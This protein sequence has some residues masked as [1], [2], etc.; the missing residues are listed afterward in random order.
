MSELL[1][2]NSAEWYKD[3]VIYQVHVRSFFD[4][5]ADGIGDFKG[6]IQ[7][8]EYIKFLGVTAIWLLPFYP[9]PLKDEGYDVADYMNINPIY[10][11][12]NEFKAFLKQAH[13][14]NIKVI[15]EL[16]INHTSSQHAW[17]QRAR[18]AKPG[19]RWRNFYTWSD[20]GTEYAE[21][22]VIFNHTETSNWT[23]DPV[24]QAFYWHRFFS[25]QPDLN[26]EN[27][28]VQ[29]EVLKIVDFWF[30]LGV[31]GLRL[32]A[33]PYLFQREGTNCENLE[34]THQFLKKLNAH[35]QNKFQ[36]RFL[37]AE[38]NQWSEETVKYF[39]E[40]GDECQMAY[41]FPLLPK[42][43][44]AVQMGDRRPLVDVIEQTP[45]IPENCQWAI[46]LRNHD[47]LALEM[48]TDEECDYMYRIYAQDKQMR[49]NDG[50]RRRLAPLMGGDRQKIE[51]L[52]ALLFSLPGTPIIYY[53]DEI[54]MGD[55]I[56]LEDRNSVRTPM[57]WSNENNAGFSQATPQKLYFPVVTDPE[58]HYHMVNVN[59]QRQNPQSLL[60]WMKKIIELRNQHQ[61]FG[62][63]AI[64]F[65]SPDNTKI[66]A[67]YRIY[68]EEVILVLFN[69]S[70]NIQSTFIDLSAFSGYE[71]IEMFGKN[72]F[73]QI[74]EA[75]Y[76]FTLSGYGFMWLEI[77]KVEV[78]EG[79]TKTLPSIHLKKNFPEVFEQEHQL[80]KLE[81]ILQNYL[82]FREDYDLKKQRV[83]KLS[84]IE[85]I[86]I[87]AL[88]S[89]VYFLIFEVDI[90]DKP[91]EKYHLLLVEKSEYDANILLGGEEDSYLK[92]SIC[93][94]IYEG[95]DLA[96]FLLDVTQIPLVWKE[97]SALF[98]K[99]SQYKGILGN[100]KIS[101]SKS[102]QNNLLEKDN[103]NIINIY[104]TVFNSQVYWDHRIRLKLYKKSEEGLHPEIEMHEV[105]N[106]N[107][108]LKL[109][110]ILVKLEYQV[111]KEKTLVGIVQECFESQKNAWE[112]SSEVLSPAVRT[113]HSSVSLF[114]KSAE[115]KYFGKVE[116]SEE[117]GNV[118]GNYKQ[119]IETLAERTAQM[120]LSLAGAE[121]FQAEK[122]TL[123]DQR[124]LYQSLRSQGIWVAK[125]LELF[126]LELDPE[127]KNRVIA[128][129]KDNSLLQKTMEP[130]L[131]SKMGGKKIRCHGDY[132]LNQLLWIKDDFAVLDWEG[133][134]HKP[135]SERKI[136]RPLFKDL[137]NILNSFYYHIQE[138]IAEKNVEENWGDT[139][140]NSL[141]ATISQLFLKKYFQVPGISE[142]LPNE[143]ENIVLLLKLYL[144]DKMLYRI[145]QEVNLNPEKIYI[146]CQALLDLIEA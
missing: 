98:K 12:L 83:L 1:D 129:V 63:G 25:H 60:R 28:E 93:K 7:K 136:K 113:F 55:N 86:C 128:A 46:F 10:G 13:A 130:L 38:A 26:F 29:K 8:L 117:M 127:L 109:P 70:K 84:I 81:K 126:A 74:N 85:H 41:N 143:E 33:I 66:L 3:V 4:S 132:H 6:L 137:A 78:K 49:I 80:K 44:M 9:S 37:L 96:F 71:V 40:K 68:Q 2:T 5:N 20:T 72:E 14:Y 88:P 107:S 19:S 45:S 65:L 112:F 134:A 77:K 135:F 42:L 18:L 90:K 108:S 118:L 48:L 34:E 30:N 52:N 106:S 11:T 69:L 104:Q 116:F 73:P 120:H 122:F 146:P 50:I 15:T 24:A 76:F 145:E 142:F 131:F 32:D 75:P 95:S 139:A 43:Y 138:I 79:L 57:Q 58:Y 16:V 27:P 141:Y 64:V 21:A 82:D 115:K 47:A 53:G 97:L 133:E 67:F 91:A 36:N 35:I 125:Q 87:S 119:V 140:T 99:D 105:L 31:D 62:R 100:L 110:R 111:G 101:L 23:W 114:Q 144:I 39:G 89:P 17:F 92:Q 103:L 102:S 51:L 94:I 56:Y 124:A 59:L 123:Y 54:G 22:R 61:A 121:T